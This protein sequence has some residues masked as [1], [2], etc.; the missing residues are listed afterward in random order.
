[1]IEEDGGLYL[2]ENNKNSPELSIKDFSRIQEIFTRKN[3][4][5]EE[6]FDDNVFNNFCNMLAGLDSEQ[7]DLVISLTEK[8]LW[9]QESEYPK[10]FSVA[11]KSFI[12]S[13]DFIRG[14]KI[15][16][17]PLLP[18]EDFGK[19]KSSVYLL[20]SVKSHLHAIQ[21][22][23]S[24]FSI[25]FADSPKFVNT[26]LVKNGYTFCLIDDFL[27]TGETV[28]RA[29]KYFLDQKITKDMIAI[30]TLVGMDFGISELTKKGY[31][32]YTDIVCEKGLSINGDK[33]QIELME[34][35]EESI[36]V[37]DDCKFGYGASEAL[38]RMKRTPNN[39]FPIYWLNNKK[40]KYAPFPR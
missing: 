29:I 30:V 23:Y 34:N 5:I 4:P 7:R 40:N 37:I 19:S 2:K 32:I 16:I 18:E 11:F 39:T 10:C 24:D 6:I 22:K 20:Y 31:N 26:N 13:Y 25:T 38:V 1:M 21:R 28:E 14:K 15:C 12:T 36:N 35:I 3:W 8:F 17:C 33:K 27:G 9:V